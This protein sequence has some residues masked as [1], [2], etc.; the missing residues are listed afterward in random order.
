MGDGG[1][2]AGKQRKESDVVTSHGV[3]M[4][5]QMPNGSGVWDLDKNNEDE[6][7]PKPTRALSK[8]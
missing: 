2:S 6:R 1:N 7:E 3:V 4:R 8:A 5:M